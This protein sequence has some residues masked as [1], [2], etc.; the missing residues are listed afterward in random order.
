MKLY[1]NNSINKQD[2]QIVEI[3]S[4]QKQKENTDKKH[5]EENN[6][7]TKESKKVKKR[8]ETSLKEK[9]RQSMAQW[10]KVL[11]SESEGSQFKSYKEL[12]HSW[13][14]PPSL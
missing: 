14:N 13:N 6:L 10:Y 5:S 4:I 2:R 3:N 7:Q 1:S 12:G 9:H 8:E 11:Q